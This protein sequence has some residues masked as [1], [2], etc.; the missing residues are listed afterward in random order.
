MY[1]VH[2]AH[3]LLE[4]AGLGGSVGAARPRA[5]IRFLTG[6]RPQVPHEAARSGASVGAARPRAGIRFLTGV[7]PQVP[8][9]AAWLGG[10]VGAARPR[11][12]IRFLT[13]VRPQVPREGLG[14]GAEDATTVPRAGV[15]G[16]QPPFALATAHSRAPARPRDRYPWRA[17]ATRPS[18][19]LPAGAA[20]A[21]DSPQHDD[22]CAPVARRVPPVARQVGAAR[23]E[24]ASPWTD[25]GCHSPYSPCRL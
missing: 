19:W 20:R 13:G 22:R 18:W 21:S 5:G 8:R 14:G 10:S 16:Q 9:E 6:V 1:F 3:V 24:R 12:G 11:A 25:R 15:S 23:S 7:R 17:S 2:S 4:V